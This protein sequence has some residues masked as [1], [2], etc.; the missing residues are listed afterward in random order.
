MG[1]CVLPNF[2][3]SGEASLTHQWRPEGEESLPH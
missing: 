2:G 1:V 3:W